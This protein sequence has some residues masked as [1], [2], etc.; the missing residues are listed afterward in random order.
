MEKWRHRSVYSYVR[1][2]VEVICQLHALAASLLG[3]S[4]WFLLDR[5]PGPVWTLRR[6]GKSLASAGIE[7]RFF[8]HPA[9]TVK[10]FICCFAGTSTADCCVSKVTSIDPWARSLI[11][12]KGHVLFLSY[13]TPPGS[14]VRS[15]SHRWLPTVGRGLLT[16]GQSN[17][18]EKL[19]THLVIEWVQ[20][21]LQSPYT[22]SWLYA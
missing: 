7:P 1:H 8:C 18:S 20:L 17:W 22:P 21:S 12:V 15:I 19:F 14:P 2:E 6:R 10:L 3:L 4:P 11:P 16:R 9:R 5:A 13:R